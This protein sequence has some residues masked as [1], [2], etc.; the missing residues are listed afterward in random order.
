MSEPALCPLIVLSDSIIVEQGTGKLSIIGGFDRFNVP[1]VPF[2]IG[3]FFITVG[4]TNLTGPVKELNVTVRLEL[5]DSGHVIHSASQKMEFVSGPQTMM[6]SNVI[7]FAIPMIG[8][9]FPQAGRYV[10]VAL[11]NNEEIGRRYIEV[12]I[13]TASAAPSP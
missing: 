11:L 5:P 13:I 7:N 12:V 1:Q 8:A 4:I 3:R 2:Q 6:P 10:V 9:T